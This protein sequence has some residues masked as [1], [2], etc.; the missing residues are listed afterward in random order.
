M[1]PNKKWSL[2]PIPRQHD[3]LSYL[4]SLA[5][6]NLD[7][8]LNAQ[9]IEDQFIYQCYLSN[10]VLPFIVCEPAL[11]LLPMKR[12]NGLLGA[13]N[14]AEIA[15]SG[16]ASAAAFDR[17]FKEA[18]ENAN[19]YFD[20]INTRNKL[21]PQRFSDVAED[22]CLVF[23]GAGGEH[24]C[25]AYIPISAIDREKTI[26]DQTLYWHIAKSEDEA[27]YICG[28]LNSRALGETIADFQ[29]EGA[30]GKRHIHKLPYAVTPEFDVSNPAHQLVADK[31]RVIKNSLVVALN[32]SNAA[33][34]IPPSRST[35]QVRRGKIRELLHQLNEATDYE[36]VCRD[37]YGV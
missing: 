35:L 6:E 37:L 9:N 32:A 12:V 8:T 14:E 29:P 4:V 36:A 11:G 17:V 5:K 34:Y 19:Q 23:A 20:R 7:F 18:R 16:S 28:L 13:V 10:H 21:N 2:Q 15:M 1:Q 22:A 27:L 25:A 30:M 33:Q 26:I 24:T 31:T 3:E